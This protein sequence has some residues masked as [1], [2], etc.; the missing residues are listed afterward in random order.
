VKSEWDVIT[1]ETLL[2]RGWI[3]SHLD[4]NHGGD[5]PRKEEFVSE[6]VPYISANCLVDDHVDMSRAKYLSQSRADLLR[7]GIARDGDVLFAHNAT[8]GP[9]AVLHTDEEKVIL[10]TSLT[11]YRCNQGYILPGYLAYYMRSFEFKRQYLQVMGQ[12][13]RNQVPITKQREFFHIIPPI[14]VQQRIVSILDEAFE[15]IVTAKA[16]AEKNLL[17]T[18]ALFESHLE[19]VFSQRGEGWTIKRIGEVAKHSLGKMLDRVKNRGMPQTYLRN[20]NVRWFTFDLSDLAQMLFLEEESN[21]YT[22]A[23]GDVVVCEGG[24][25]GRAAIWEEDYLIYFQ[26]ALHRVRFYEPMHSRWFVYYL[27]AQDRSGELKQHFTGT[28]IQ[29]FTGVALDRLQLPLPPLFELRRAVAKFEDLSS[30][31]QRLES[32]YQ[33]KLATLEELKKSLLHHAFSGQL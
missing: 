13:T 1:L 24:Y 16:N 4:G 23:K 29:H 18:R 6:G 17:N 25:P 5:Y 11:Y 22:V 27:Y 3:E 26:K 7:K 9:V 8:V 30:E 21:K 19:A 33:R 12:S 20:V 28:G 15:A 14:P 32:L 31:T 2:Q 10:G